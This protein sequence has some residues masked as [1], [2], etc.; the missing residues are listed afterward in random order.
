MV[1]FWFAVCMLKNKN[2]SILITL[3]KAQVQVDQ[4]PQHK[5]DT[6]NLIEDKLIDTEREMS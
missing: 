2:K 1:M 5:L 4:G 6:L 3:H